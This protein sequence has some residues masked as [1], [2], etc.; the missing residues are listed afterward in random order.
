[1]QERAPTRRVL[2]FRPSRVQGGE[3][4]A[5]GRTEG[6]SKSEDG[7][8][9]GERGRGTVAD[10][11]RSDHRSRRARFSEGLGDWLKSIAIAFALFLVVRTSLVEA[12]KIPTASMEGTLRVGDFLLVNKAV[13]GA[14]L[15]GLDVVLPPLAEPGRGDVIVF[16]SLE[17]WMKLSEMKQ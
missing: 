8:R 16:H 17:G 9:D 6:R 13:Y 15:P 12:F 4:G 5:Q 7:V 2:T 3:G 14:H 11:L 10:M 1:M